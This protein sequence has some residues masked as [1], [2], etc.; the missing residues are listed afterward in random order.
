MAQDRAAPMTVSDLAFLAGKSKPQ[1]GMRVAVIPKEIDENYIGILLPNPKTNKPSPYYFNG[2]HIYEILESDRPHASWFVGNSVI[3]KGSLLMAIPIHPLF[4]VIPLM[5]E[6]GGEMYPIDEYFLDTCYQPIAHLVKPHFPSI[7][8]ALPFDDTSVWS[9]DQQKLMN[10]LCDRVLRLIPF[11]KA[12][13]P[14]DD[15]FLVEMG[16]DVVRHYIR[17]DLAQKLRDSLKAMFPK[18][19]P[20]RVVNVVQINMEKEAESVTPPPKPKPKPQ[21]QVKKVKRGIDSF[22]APVKK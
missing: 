3:S 13:T 7:C 20:T 22:F 9:L 18:A 8:S 5:C 15:S 10:W 16:Y 19:F 14:V 4:L 21:V 11:F 6:R 1:I 17:A 12:S 2:T